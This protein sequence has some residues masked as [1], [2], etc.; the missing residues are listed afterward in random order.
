MDDGWSLKALHRRIMLSAAYRQ[1]SDDRP[2]GRAVDPE[3]ALLWRMNR[4][5]LDFE[6]TRDALLAVSGRLDPTVGGPPIA[7]H[8]RRRLAD[9]RTL[10]G[11]IDRLQPAGPVPHVR[12]PRPERH[13]PPARRDDRAAA[14]PVPHEPPVRA[15]VAPRGPARR[16][17]EV[18]ARAPTPDA[19]GRPALSRSSSAATPDAASEAAAGREFLGPKPEPRPTG[20]ATCRRCCSANEFVFID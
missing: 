16:G 11:K 3:N 2:E 20:S 14:G 10:Y 7:G 5:R 4:R 19:Q 9:R 6:A 18:A 17:R 12:L 1:A 8:P 15:R 13:Q